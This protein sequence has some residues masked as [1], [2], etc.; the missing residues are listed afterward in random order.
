MSHAAYIAWAYGVAGVALAG[1]VAYVW[2]DLRRQA[3]KLAELE[4]RGVRRRRA[5]ALT[6]GAESG[7]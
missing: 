2:T 4:S 5:P 1:L 6:S 3:R 7:T